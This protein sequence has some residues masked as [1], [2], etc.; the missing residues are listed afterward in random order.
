MSISLI[1]AHF[2]PQ[3]GSQKTE[4]TGAPRAPRTFIFRRFPRFPTKKGGPNAKKGAL[5]APKPPTFKSPLLNQKSFFD[6]GILFS[7]QSLL[8]I[9]SGFCYKR[10]YPIRDSSLIQN[11]SSAFRKSFSFILWN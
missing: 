9:Q 5:R 1:F 4:K 6:S 7:F 11:S 10:D 8:S 3:T 2:R